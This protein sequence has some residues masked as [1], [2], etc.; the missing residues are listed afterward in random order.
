MLLRHIAV[1]VLSSSVFAAEVRLGPETP[2]TPWIPTEPASYPQT[3]PAIASNGRDFLAIWRDHR[4]KST[5]LR[6][7]LSR[8]DGA[9]HPVEPLGRRFRE[10]H[11]NSV[12][13]LAS[14]GVDYLA[15]WQNPRGWTV[16]QRLDE[17]GTPLA[18]EQW[19]GQEWEKTSPRVLASNGST[20]LLLTRDAVFLLDR[21]GVVLDRAVSTMGVLS[22][23][24]WNGRY[25][26][27]GYE[28]GLL[29][30]RTIDDH[31]GR[32][33]SSDILLPDVPNVETAVFLHNRILCVWTERTGPE[34]FIRVFMMLDGSGQ[35]VKPASAVNLPISYMLRAETDGRELL[36]AA[37]AR[38]VRM[39]AEGEVRDAEPLPLFTNDPWFRSASNGKTLVWIWSQ[40]GSWS[41]LIDSGDIVSLAFRNFDELPPPPA[42]NTLVA[43]S[44]RAQEHA[45]VAQAGPHRMV[46]WR[47]STGENIRGAIDGV[48]VTIGNFGG[49]PSVAAG[50]D[51]F[52]VA[53]YGFASSWRLL[54]RRYAFDGTPL[55]AQPIV[56][57]SVAPFIDDDPG[58]ATDGSSFVISVPVGNELR[59]ARVDGATGFVSID[60]TYPCK[61]DC[62]VSYR[63]V[64]TPS[65]WIVPFAKYFGFFSPH[66]AI[67]WS[68]S[69]AQISHS[70][71][72]TAEKSTQLECNNT[73]CLRVAVANAGERVSLVYPN[74][75]ELLF[76]P[77]GG[78]LRRLKIGS[79]VHGLDAAWNGSEYVVV[80]STA[81]GEALRAMRFDASWR[82][83]DAEPF[84]ISPAGATTD[85]PSI[86]VTDQGV[87]IAYSRSTPENAWAPR[88]FTRTLDR[89][90]PRRRAARH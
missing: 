51:S 63:P 32:L 21:N 10:I 67:T 7:Y 3:Y 52:L 49:I 34:S 46:V 84:E 8:L 62:S 74:F 11:Y 37:G 81:G 30:L 41:G 15:A 35:I 75:D 89:L 33:A 18:A 70:G 55:D 59:L 2:V 5:T 36:L 79:W 28:G 54:A 13:H 83:I 25:R 58:I 78:G 65:E 47:D 31:S 64:R 57:A 60:V 90:A 12:P 73:G 71:S 17:N 1:L 50:K 20:Y 29:T 22:L 77:D 23:D 45:R 43:F 6:L 9:G 80:W 19:I 39:S 4:E 40:H 87:V 27:I 72:T 85:N 68:P 53:W 44:G 88:A 26:M 82:A 38:A 69:L 86:A 61:T 56:V 66:V 16:V 76:V 42:A 48:E 24:A 14:D